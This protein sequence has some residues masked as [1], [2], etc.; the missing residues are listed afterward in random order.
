ML[1]APM[2]IRPRASALR[3]ASDSGAVANKL[4]AKRSIPAFANA[5]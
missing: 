5:S 3:E 2:P 1:R 4:Y